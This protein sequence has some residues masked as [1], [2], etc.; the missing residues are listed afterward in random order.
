[1]SNPLKLGFDID[2]V[3]ANF[4]TPWQQLLIKRT[5]KDLFSPDALVGGAAT[6]N[7]DLAAGYTKAETTAAW[8]WVKANPVWWEMLPPA[9][10]MSALLDRWSALKRVYAHIYFITARYGLPKDQTQRWLNRYFPHDANTLLM[11]GNK[12][13]AAKTLQLDAYIDDRLENAIDVAVEAKGEP[14]VTRSYLLNYRHN[15]GAEEMVADGS[16]IRVATVAEMLEM[17]LSQ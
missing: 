16:I 3:L 9:P 4:T 17:E 7:W 10:G 1:M 8:E 6:W 13:I 14:V 15:A 11:A 12:G 2:G 5:G